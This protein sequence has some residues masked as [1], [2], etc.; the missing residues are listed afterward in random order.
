MPFSD[1][2]EGAKGADRDRLVDALRLA[3]QADSEAREATRRARLANERARRWARA[4][5]NLVAEHNGQLT[6]YDEL[7]DQ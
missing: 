2:P 6:I 3:R 7:E 1:I 4:Y 5:E